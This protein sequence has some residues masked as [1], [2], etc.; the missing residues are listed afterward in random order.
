[1]R[2]GRIKDERREQ[3]LSATER[4]LGRG[5]VDAVTM[6]AVAA[7]AGV[8]LRLVQYYGQSK[9]ELLTATLDRL[10]ASSVQRWQRRTA[11]RTAG[12]SAIEAIRAFIAEALPTDEESSA[13][14]R[15]GV[16][17]EVLAVSGSQAA[18]AAYRRHLRALADHLADVVGTSGV[19]AVA[20]AQIAHEV[21][22]LSHGLGTLVMAGISTAEDATGVA[23]EYL[24]GLQSRLSG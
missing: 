20:A 12:T 10:A 9:D 2:D 3:I 24:T 14:H 13:F 17:L 19:S 5:G 21:M 6:R 15:V 11:E 16:S 22:A 23:E 8:S 4:L 1:M 7:E 18:G